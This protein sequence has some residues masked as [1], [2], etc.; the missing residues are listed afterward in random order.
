MRELCTG[1]LAK[2]KCPYAVENMIIL[3]YPNI[4]M[5]ERLQVSII[6]SIVILI[7]V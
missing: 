4:L 7:E 2:S 3:A 5:V 6:F 1:L